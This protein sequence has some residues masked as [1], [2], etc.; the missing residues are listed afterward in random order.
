MF[1]KFVTDFLQWLPCA[2][3]PRQAKRVGMAFREVVVHPGPDFNIDT[4]VH[5]GVWHEV[6]LV[7]IVIT[8]AAGLLDD[9]DAWLY[10]GELARVIKQRQRT[11]H[12][13]ME[14]LHNRSRLFSLR[15]AAVL[16]RAIRVSTIAL[17]IEDHVRLDATRGWDAMFLALRNCTSWRRASITGYKHEFGGFFLACG[18][19]RLEE[20][21]IEP[22]VSSYPGTSL[23]QWRRTDW[24]AFPR[25]RALVL[26]EEAFCTGLDSFFNLSGYGTLPGLKVLVV[27]FDGTYPRT[28]WRIEAQTRLLGNLAACGARGVVLD[29]RDLAAPVGDPVRYDLT[30]LC[31]EIR[32]SY[33]AYP[34]ALDHLAKSSLQLERLVLRPQI[35]DQGVITSIRSILPIGSGRVHWVGVMELV[36][37]EPP[38][39]TRVFEHPLITAALGYLQMDCERC[40]VTL[41]LPR[42]Y[43]APNWD[44]EPFLFRA[45]APTSK[46]PDP[47]PQR[48]SAHQEQG[49]YAGLGVWQGTSSM[50]GEGLLF[51]AWRF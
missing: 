50:P 41:R 11:H 10:P 42:S 30:G 35:V 15:V 1:E 46:G 28:Q 36:I 44:L 18:A 17:H 5:P 47:Q 49:P 14:P 40:G 9:P 38:T 48:Q 6:G 13:A 32:L 12:P 21:A 2:P 3:P 20:I 33:D 22:S 29:V 8:S 16:A 25:L 51:S 24:P 39:P 19:E 31:R 23:E 4:V 34:Y 7:R 27:E 37:V 45:S 43:D 26:T